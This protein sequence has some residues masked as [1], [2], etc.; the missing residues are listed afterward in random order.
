MW[1][2]AVESRDS[3]LLYHQGSAHNWGR[4]TRWIIL[5]I[6]LAGIGLGAAIFLSHAS[7]PL[8]YRLGV[9]ISS[10]V[11]WIPIAALI[12]L[13]QR[14]YVHTIHYAPQ[15]GRLEIVVHGVWNGRR[16][17]V[18][19][20]A[21]GGGGSDDVAADIERPILAGRALLLRLK[22]RPLPLF[23]DLRGEIPDEALFS[24]LLKTGAIR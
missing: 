9:A 17:L 15:A 13:L 11:V 5:A 20:L 14:R 1:M 10:G 19:V 4:W 6:A 23:V 16:I 18:P 3:V 8:E 22:G 12:I 21:A 24:Q 7:A 2:S